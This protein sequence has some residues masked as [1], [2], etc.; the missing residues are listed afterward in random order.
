MAAPAP[1]LG[2]VAANSKEQDRARDQLKPWRAWYSLKRWKDLRRKILARDAYTCMQTGV[3]LV[4]K[5]PAPNSPVVDH[6]RE[7]NGDPFLFWDEDNLQAVSKQYHDTE[8]Q[9]IERARSG[10]I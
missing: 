8:K 3:A 9:R 2:A 10:Y 1:R 5:A 7:H 4:G 6:I